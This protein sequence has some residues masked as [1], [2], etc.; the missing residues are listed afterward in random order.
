MKDHGVQNNEFLRQFSNHRLVSWPRIKPPSAAAPV[1][2][3]GTATFASS[4]A[5]STVSRTVCSI[6]ST[7]SRVLFI[8]SARVSQPSSKSVGFRYFKT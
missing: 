1:T 2:T 7:V 3:S 5:P 4:A 8:I 6:P